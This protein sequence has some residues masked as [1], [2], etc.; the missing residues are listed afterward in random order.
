MYSVEAA[1]Q[2]QQQNQG[3]GQAQSQQGQSQVQPEAQEEEEDEPPPPPT[4][5]TN[6]KRKQPDSATPDAGARKRRQRTAAAGGSASAAGGEDGEDGQDLEVGPNGGAKHWTEEEKT[7]FFT[8]MLTN[9]EH[10]EAFKTRMNTVFREVRNSSCAHPQ[11]S[12]RGEGKADSCVNQCSAELFPGRKSYTA[13]KSCYHRNLEVFK[14]IHA[15]QA[16]SANHLRQL[17]IENPQAEQPSADSMLDTARVAG[18]NV[19]NL[20]V[21]VIDRW[22]ETG[23][24]NLFKRRW[25]HSFFTVN[26]RIYSYVGQVP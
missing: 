7:R 15:F 26:V 24:Y 1:Q 12:A 2:Q 23:W 18:L 17:Q 20:N 3:Q 22:Y 6:G 25:L 10:W 4:A 14:Q 16:F 11:L 21:K 13:L 5:S 19:G 8:W 9:D